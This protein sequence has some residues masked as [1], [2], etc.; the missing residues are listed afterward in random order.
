ML[1]LPFWSPEVF[2]NFMESVQHYF[3]LFEFNGSIH[4][5]IRWVSFQLFDINPIRIIGQVMPWVILISILFLAFVEKKANI[6]RLPRMMLLTFSIYFAL[7][8]TV[9]PWYI[10]VF[11][12]FSILSGYRWAIFWTALI[13]LSYHTYRHGMVDEQSWVIALEYLPIYAF[14][15][16]EFGVLN[17]L[18]KKWALQKAQ[19]KVERLKDLYKNEERI[20]EIG[21][22]NGALVKLLREAGRQVEAVDVENKTYFQEVQPIIYNGENL[23]VTDKQFSAVQMITMLHHVKEPEKLIAE[24]KRT[25]QQLV[26]MED[27][28]SNSFQKYITWFTDS[29]VN[30]EFSAHPHTNKTDQEWREIFEHLDLKVEK[31][32]YHKGFLLFFQQVTYELS[33]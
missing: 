7:A 22:G 19:I 14:A 4:Q 2:P 20:L 31:V 21:C 10:V 28:Y 24:A 32:K 5:I 12:V 27:I 17:F 33:M 8:T 18:K 26:I 6:A 29:I 9:N 13:P 3:K 25:G 23:P 1:F 15:F 11:I 30:W 16:Y